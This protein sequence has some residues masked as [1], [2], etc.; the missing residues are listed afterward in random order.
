MRNAVCLVV[1]DVEFA[2]V[3]LAEYSNVYEVAPST[4]DQDTVE[5]A[6]ELAVDT[7]G[8]VTRL[9]NEF[10]SLHEPSSPFVSTARTR[11]YQMP[12][13]SSALIPLSPS[14]AMS[15]GTARAVVVLIVTTPSV[16]CGLRA[17]S[18]S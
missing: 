7:V 1:L 12:S 14:T 6:P 15:R 18:S 17:S 11:K 8:A 3:G 16:I 9:L 10:T 13:A 5:P 2:N 4:V